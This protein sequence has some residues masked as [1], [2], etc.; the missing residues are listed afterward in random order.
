[1]TKIN[2]YMDRLRENH[3]VLDEEDWRGASESL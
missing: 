2:G 3:E 1:L